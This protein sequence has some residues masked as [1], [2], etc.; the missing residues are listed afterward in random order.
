[1]LRLIIITLILVLL[2]RTQITIGPASSGHQ[3]VNPVTWILI[4]I[5]AA[6]IAG[7]I[8][9]LGHAFRRAW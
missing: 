4:L 8:R 3:M 7:W 6:L 9:R 5:L 1:M 2:A